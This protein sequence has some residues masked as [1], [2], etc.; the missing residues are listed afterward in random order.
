MD[1]YVYTHNWVMTTIE[2]HNSGGKTVISLNTDSSTTGY[3]YGKMNVDT[4]PITYIKIN[5]RWRIDSNK[6]AKPI[7]L[8][9]HN[10]GNRLQN[11][12]VSNVSQTGHQSNTLK[13]ND[14]QVLLFSLSV[15]LNSLRPHGLQ[16]S[17]FPILR[18]LPEFAQT[19]VHWVGDA[20]QPSHPLS[21][22]SP[23]A[24]NLSQ[25]Q[26]LFQWISSSHQVAKVLELQHQF[27]QWIFKVYFF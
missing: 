24:F 16:H 17:G 2:L 12:G 18:Y 23:L 7:K 3:L 14:W 11:L 20:I 26:G 27:F 4:Y 13:W 19:H 10:K 9:G 22:P 15:M 25:H 21:S 5:S 6:K 8:L 1:E